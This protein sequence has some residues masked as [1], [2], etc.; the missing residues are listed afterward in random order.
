[1]HRRIFTVFLALCAL[2]V[3][4][5]PLAATGIKEAPSET[6]EAKTPTRSISVQVLKGPTGMG[7]I[8]LLDEKPSFTPD[9]EVSYQ[10]IG[11]P[12]VLVSRVLS[13]EVDVAALPTN[14]AAKLYNKGVPYKLAAVN[15]LGV[16]YLVSTDSDID[17]WDDIRGK[18][19]YNAAEGANPDIIFRHLAKEQGLTPEEDTRLVYK[20]HTEIA[21][22]LLAGKAELAV[23]P[24]PFVTQVLQK[25]EKATVAMDLQEE[26]KRVHGDD[27]A[28]PMGCLVVKESLINEEGAFMEAFMQRYAEGISWVN[29]NT[30]AAGELIAEYKM[31]FPAD[32]ASEAIPRAKIRYIEGQAARDMLEPYFSVLRDFNPATV[33]GKL[34]DA[35]FYYSSD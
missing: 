26:W 11:S 7:M 8:P 2:F 22:L 1:M 15:T 27:A 35:G 10:V 5:G 31:G 16:L 29:E 28:I 14:V 34:P 20:A 21:Q 25:S 24:E 19:V 17:S 23:L 12:N 4:A 18:T 33:G 9:T 32:A 3:A 30:Q 13:N 6:G